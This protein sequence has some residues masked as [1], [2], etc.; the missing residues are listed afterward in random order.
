MR[1]LEFIFWRL[2]SLTLVSVAQDADPD[3]SGMKM[4]TT[5]ALPSPHVSSGTGWQPASVPEHDW[6]ISR[7]GWDLM[8][9]GEIFVT[10]NQQGGPRGEGKA[11]SENYFMFMEQHQLVAGHDFIS[12]DVFCGIADL[13]A[14]RFS[15]AVS[16]GRDLSRRAAGGPS[17]SA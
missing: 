17:A 2:A 9:H 14:S 11:E 10:Y 3:M 15:R 8:A 7:A 5:M 16:D 1:R 6:M 4:D 12:R 13:A